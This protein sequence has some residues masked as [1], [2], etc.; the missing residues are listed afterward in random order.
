MGLCVF[1]SFTMDVAFLQPL[2]MVKVLCFLDERCM[3]NSIYFGESSEVG[4]ALGTLLR[5]HILKLWLCCCLECQQFE[6]AVA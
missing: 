2:V 1:S 5:F 4:R 6:T 3:G